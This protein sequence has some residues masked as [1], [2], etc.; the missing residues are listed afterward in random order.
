MKRMMKPL[1]YLSFLLVS[2]LFTASI[3]AHAQGRDPNLIRT[4]VIDAGHGGK[5]PGAIGKGPYKTTEKDIA[6]AVSLL[7]GKYIKEAFPDVEVVYTRKDDRFVELMERSQIANRAKADLFISIHCNSNASASPTGSET[8]VMGLHK[9]EANMKVAMKE[10][11]SILLEEGHQLKYDGFDPKDP[12]SM[13]ALSIRQ[14]VHLDHSLLFSSLVQTQFRERIGRGDRGVKQAGFLVISYTTMP[15]VLIEL[16]FLSNPVE[17]EFL[18]SS[19]GQ[20]Y[21]ASAIYRAF[22]EYKVMREVGAMAPAP[23]A[24][25]A[26]EVVE[27]PATPAATPA[28]SSTVQFKVQVV[29]SSKRID[30]KSKDLKGLDKVEEHKGAG[31]FRYTVGSEPTLDAARKVQD[32]CRELGFEGAFIVAFKGSERIDLQEAI[33]LAQGL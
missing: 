23:A 21:L 22:K 10:N 14:N 24:P 31:M 27:K 18:Q 13:I 32:R 5:D 25:P 17:E 28:T 33:K 4:V 1:T 12:E 3:E 15:A 26:P 7:T 9:T 6:L 8:Y 16:G 20:D 19:K 2:V 29:T 30:T 11:A